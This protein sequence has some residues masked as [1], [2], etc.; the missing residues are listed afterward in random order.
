M[1]RAATYLRIS[2][3][4][5]GEGYGVERQREDCS[6]L[7]ESR[8]W[9]SVA[10]YT[11]NDTSADGRKPRPQF[12]ALIHAIRALE[13]DVVVAWSLDR[14]TRTARDRLD[15]VEACRDTNVMIALVRGTD[16]DPSTPGGRLT[17]GVLG[18]VAQHEIDQK[19][20]RQS[21]AMEQAAADGRWVG[22]RRAF[23]YEADGVTPRP[24]EAVV[25]QAAFAALVAGES[26]RGI[27]RDW[28]AAGFTTGQSPWRHTGIGVNGFSPWRADS[29]RRVLRNPR[30]A[31]LRAHRGTIVGPAKWPG[32]VDEATWR[33]AQT[34]LDHPARSTGGPGAMAK[35]FL[36]GLASCAACGMLVHGGGAKHGKPVYRCRSTQQLPDQR[37]VVEGTHVNRLAAPVDDYVTEVIVAR[38]SRPDARQLLVDE[39]SPDVAGLQEEALAL[40]ARQ[41]ELAREFGAA[42]D[43]PLPAREYRAMR[44]PLSEKLRRI[45]AQIADAGRVNV[46]GDL[47]GVRDVQAAWDRLGFDRRRSVLRIL[48]GVRLHAVGRGTRT[49]RPDTV[50]IV[51]H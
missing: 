5:G 24:R 15:L 37:P 22:G 31:A 9:T 30:Y 16:M 38:L 39:E 11:E 4:R 49:F 21:R 42:S 35:H 40:Q 19:S 28:N 41:E 32:I 13:V 34:H 12:R 14:L 25:I 2:A 51:W 48:A 18:E 29:V 47:V 46:L 17:I 3:D 33:A 20:D 23:G 1:T 50:D 27:A 45:E 43:D 26:L 8:G 36:S 6:E 44:A 10:T 7:V